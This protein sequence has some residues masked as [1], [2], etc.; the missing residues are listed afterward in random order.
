MGYQ[1]VSVD[2][3]YQFSGP[4][5]DSWIKQVAPTIA[6]QTRRNGTAIRERPYWGMRSATSC[7]NYCVSATSR[8]GLLEWDAR[9]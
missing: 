9:G 8:S 4:E 2:P 3:I 5:I 1:V 6:E 7:S